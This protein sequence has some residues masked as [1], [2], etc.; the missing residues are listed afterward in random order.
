MWLGYRGNEWTCGCGNGMGEIFACG[1]GV[2]VGMESGVGGL[3]PDHQ[4]A[5]AHQYVVCSIANCDETTPKYL[6]N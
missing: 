2:L 6:G 4:R 3:L 1:V 5:C